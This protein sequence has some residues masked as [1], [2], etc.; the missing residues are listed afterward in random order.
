MVPQWGWMMAR[1]WAMLKAA[2]WE[3]ASG[4]GWGFQWVNA[5]S[6]TQHAW[7]ILAL[8]LYLLRRNLRRDGSATV[9]VPARAAAALMGGLALHA[10]GYVAQ[11]PRISVLALLLFMWGVLALG[12]GRRW[13]GA[14]AFTIAFMVFALPV[15]ALDTVGF[16]LQ[17]WVVRAGERIA[18]LAGIGVIRNGT[19]LFAPDG[20]YQY[21]VVAA[22][23][24]IRSL[25]A[26]T[27]EV[28]FWE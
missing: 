11:Q 24:G 13:G 20:R 7:L 23:S 6:E 19:Q 15:N 27:A 26:L 16:W 18:H 2:E 9:P 4:R 22:C 25:M 1:G 14:A 21:D 8:S 5:E 3:R 17:R 12:G 28:R 10:I